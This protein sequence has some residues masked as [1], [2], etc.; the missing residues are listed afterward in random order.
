MWCLTSWSAQHARQWQTYRNSRGEP[1]KQRVI[2]FRSQ[3]IFTRKKE[4]VGRASFL[5]WLRVRLPCCEHKMASPGECT[6]AKIAGCIV[7]CVPLR[8]FISD[9]SPQMW[10]AA[11]GAVLVLVNG[12]DQIQVTHYKHMNAQSRDLWFTYFESKTQAAFLKICLNETNQQ[13]TV[14]R[15]QIILSQTMVETYV[16]LM[17]SPLF[18]C[19][20]SVWLPSTAGHVLVIP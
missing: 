3:E 20:A 13:N 14:S 2:S 6:T 10:K 5:V 1:E 15:R 9:V 4:G 11:G 17:F 7:F 12:S 16:C 18:F 19:V 8:L